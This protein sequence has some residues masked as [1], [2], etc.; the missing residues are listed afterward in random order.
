[1]SSAVNSKTVQKIGIYQGGKV[2]GSI[3][4]YPKK[5]PTS[6]KVRFTD[7]TGK[8][9]CSSFL[10]TKY[11]GKDKAHKKAIKF[12]EEEND[13]YGLRENRYKFISQTEIE[14]EGS[15]VDIEKDGIKKSTLITFITDAKNI[16][17]VEKYRIYIKQKKE[18]GVN[19]RYYVT[20]QNVKEQFPLTNLL[21]N[22]KIVQYIDGN[23]LNLRS[24]N[25]KEFGDV[26]AKSGS[27]NSS[28]FNINQLEYFNWP[29]I[30][31]PQNKWIL[32]KPAGTVF[33]KSDN[34]D[35]YYCRVG[36]K[37]NDEE[38]EDNNHGHYKTF[39]IHDFESDS[40]A[41]DAAKNWQY[42]IS[43]ALDMTKNTMRLLDNEYVEVKL[44]DGYAMITDIVYIP[45]LQ[46]I[47]LFLHKG[48]SDNAQYYCYTS[49]NETLVAFHSLITCFEMTDHI[50][51][52]PLDNRQ[53]NLRWTSYS[54]NNRYKITRS[55]NSGVRLLEREVANL[56][57][58]EA[59]SK[60]FGV[61]MSK[62]FY[63][64]SN[65]EKE[66]AK[67]NAIIFRKN[68]F[69][70]DPN[71]SK[72]EFTGKESEEDL[73]FLK[74]YLLRLIRD[75]TF[76]L[77]YDFDA[78]LK[79]V[80]TSI[81]DKQKM[82]NKYISI[83]LWRI[84]NMELK[85]KII[86]DKLDDLGYKCVVELDNKP[87]WNITQEIKTYDEMKILTEKTK[88]SNTK[89]VEP[90]K[91][92]V[93]KSQIKDFQDMITIRNGIIE[94]NINNIKELTSQVK[95][96]CSNEHHFCLTF[97]ELM[98]KYKWCSTCNL[99]QGEL[100]LK[101]ILINLFKEKFVKDRPEWLTNLKGI[102]LEL[103]SYCE[104]LLLAFEYNGKQ[105]YEFSPLHHSTKEDFEKRKEYDRI[106]LKKCSDNN[107]TLIVIPYTVKEK[108][109]EKYILDQLKIHKIRPTNRDYEDDSD[110][111]C[112]PKK[113]NKKVL[114]PIA[115]VFDSES[116]SDFDSDSKPEVNREEKISGTLKKFNQTEK[117]KE[118]KKKS[119]EKRSETMRQQKEELRKVAIT[120]KVCAHPDCQENK[121]IS[122]FCKKSAS[123][124][125]YQ[126]WCKEC[127][128]K[129]KREKKAQK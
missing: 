128:N 29:I 38:K 50:N 91:T 116:D 6:W 88:Y 3:N 112:K 23:T 90:N 83:N 74:K 100:K 117:G 99:S 115:P 37:K 103:D 77:C 59:K 55:E 22:Y 75:Y 51:N 105:H 121:P 25:I 110:F 63:F 61:Q 84:K 35:I 49:I 126:S 114:K 7:E 72:L 68:F 26:V 101:E 53:I 107:V 58:Y 13:L 33:K 97:E 9:H 12:L 127:T 67:N 46:K 24:S 71:S 79:Y 69:E 2:R 56:N 109:M 60:Y 41:R 48:S 80:D 18:K 14:V 92:T 65:N 125:G 8:N 54:E 78:Y 82:F 98:K 44:T 39:N 66:I 119:H 94:S 11:G 17:K 108:D 31:L 129:L 30:F 15:Y 85:N 95:V 87:F 16:D 42:N 21:V 47:P 106:K 10:F 64:K 122:E 34:S 93:T 120:H 73:M 19:I 32:G 36:T 1:M 104:K 27:M 76:N 45:L 96:M 86:D 57:C 4:L 89:I 28:N 52:N 40:A 70:I 81:F 43:Y 62:T 124:D 118:L 113:V 20:C 5:N 123:K 102:R 111:D